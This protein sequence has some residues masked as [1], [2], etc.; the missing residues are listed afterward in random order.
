MC[1]ND[2]RLSINLHCIHAFY[3]RSATEKERKKNHNYIN[4]I[5]AITK[6]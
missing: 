4:I 2:V 6:N 3:M 1:Y 5:K